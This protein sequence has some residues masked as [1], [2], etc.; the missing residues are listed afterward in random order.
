MSRRAI[1]VVVLVLA[2]VAAS[3]GNST[4]GG[5]AAAGTTGSGGSTKGEVVSV[6][7]PGVTDGEIRVGGV[8]SVTNPLG[9][10]YETAFQG[11][12]AYFEMVNAAGGVHGRKLVLAAARDDKLVNN[13]AEVQGLL[14]QDRVFA[15]LP[16]ASL[17]FSGAT[18]LVR[19]GV[20]TFGWVI[21]TD[22]QGSPSDPRRNMFGGTGSYLCLGCD[23]PVM[24]YLAKITK[25]HR[26]GVLA[27]NVAQSTECANGWKATFDEYG[28][29]A[30]SRVVYMDRSLALGATDLSVQVDKMAEAKV[31]LLLTCMDLNGVITL[32]KEMKKQRLGAVQLLPN[33][34]DQSLLD[35]YGDLFE[36]SYVFTSFVP[37]EVKP[38]PKGLTQFVEWMDRTGGHVTENSIIGWLNAALFVK[39]LRDAGPDFDRQKV[40]DAINRLTRFTADGIAAG[41][42]WTIGHDRRGERA[43]SAIVRIEDS[44]FVPVTVEEGS[45]WTCLSLESGKL[46]A[47]GA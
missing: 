30:G 21:S 40:I 37:L 26:I 27:Y 42:D 20:P 7:Q 15:V 34:Y 33:G 4:A 22:W 29:E 35:E 8:A 12:K 5:K 13:D 18:R 46:E 41:M 36:G 3:C 11:V 14:E 47:T 39:G 45:A 43:C 44:K 24:A 2:V 17:L 23:Q 28:D 31:D 10:A 32:A 19:E 6:D 38:R 25:R 1:A 16:V 9:G